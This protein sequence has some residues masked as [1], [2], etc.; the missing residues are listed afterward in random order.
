TTPQQSNRDRQSSFGIQDVITVSS[1]IRAT[2]GF[3]AD[4]L[5]GLQAQDLS[6]DKT[7]VVPFQ[8]SGICTGADAATFTSCT[9]HVWA[10]NP[11]ASLSFRS[12]ESGTFFLTFAEKNRFPT[13]KD[14][15]SYKAGR[16]IPNP[17]L[18]PENAKH[19]TTGYSRVLA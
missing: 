16:A 17:A 19:W 6:V 10:Y 13:L 14:R 3:S 12:G 18:L 7:H 5:D 11:L 4:H 8:V 9:D 2:V 15:Y 1:R